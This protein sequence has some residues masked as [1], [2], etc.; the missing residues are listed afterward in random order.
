MYV[1]QKVLLETSVEDVV[2]FGVT[3]DMW[4]HKNTNASFITLTLHYVDMNWKLSNCI[5][6]TRRLDE[7]HT[8]D[9]VRSTVM[10]ILAEFGCMK[11]A[12]VYVTDNASNMKAAFRDY[13]WLGCSG[14][15]LNLVLSHGL[16]A[17]ANANDGLPI[18]VSEL[19]DTCKQLVTMT[20]RS[21]LNSQLET[22]VKQCVVTR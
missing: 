19:I 18:E 21:K 22:T 13:T 9:C 16:Q 10:D 1:T 3:T 12:N 7:A 17:A 6:A 20:K 15:N 14:H 11:T 8:A 5:I 4:T 2:G